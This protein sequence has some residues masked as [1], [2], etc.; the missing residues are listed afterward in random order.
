MPRQFVVQLDNRIGELAH[1]SR[2]LAA[3]GVNIR[4]VSCFG[5]GTLA[6][7]FIIPDDDA[8]M[9]RVLNGLGH[10]YIEGSPI[11]VDVEDRPGGLADVAERLAAAGVNIAGTMCVGQGP[12]II[13]MAFTVDDEA[14][15]REVLG[16]NQE[17]L[18][19][20]SS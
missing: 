3:R 4:H 14:K 18:V 20:A 17:M 13:K 6:C 19:G 16:Q 15:A 11:V 9:R 10:L 8:G 1:L 7:A 5:T 12:G 2:A